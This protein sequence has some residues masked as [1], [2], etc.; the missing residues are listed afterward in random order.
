MTTP[1]EKSLEPW[2]VAKKLERVVER[3]RSMVRDVAVFEYSRPGDLCG[4]LS[5]FC[6]RILQLYVLSAVL[7]R[8][9]IFAS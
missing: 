3:M 2:E 6:S 8:Q 9:D 5:V 1:K 7:G 4:G